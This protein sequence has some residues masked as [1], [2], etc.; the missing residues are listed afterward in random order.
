MSKKCWSECLSVVTYDSVDC[1]VTKNLDSPKN[2]MNESNV[3]NDNEDTFN[4][5]S[6]NFSSND[7]NK[8]ILKLTSQIKQNFNI[9][10][11]RF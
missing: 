7:V 5:P 3:I 10:K 2:Q 11:T 8:S 9:S 4:F 6:N 1:H